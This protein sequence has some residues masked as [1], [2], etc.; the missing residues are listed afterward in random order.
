MERRMLDDSIAS[1]AVFW[2]VQGGLGCSRLKTE[3]GDGLTRLGV[4]TIE[5]G[6][7]GNGIVNRAQSDKERLLELRGQISLGTD[8]HRQAKLDQAVLLTEEERTDSQVAQTFA[9]GE[10]GE[11][12]ADK[13]TPA[14]ELGDVVVAPVA[15]DTVMELLTMN[16]IQELSGHVFSGVHR[17]RIP[18]GRS[19]EVQIAH[20]PPPAPKPCHD[21]RK[22]TSPRGTTGQLCAKVQFCPSDPNLRNIHN[23]F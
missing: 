21:G 23:A 9:L 16:P 2:Q 12:Q 14:R 1:Q 7:R 19:G 3:F 13:L 6:Q 4:G 5:Q 11:S 20:S 15:L 18:P 8:G 17:G 10:L 22:P